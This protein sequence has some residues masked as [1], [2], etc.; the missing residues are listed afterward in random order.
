MITV[1]LSITLL[2]NRSVV[3]DNVFFCFIS[4]CLMVLC[5]FKLTYMKKRNELLLYFIFEIIV[6]EHI[7]LQ[8]KCHQNNIT[9]QSCDVIMILN[10]II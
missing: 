4:N 2:N 9:I 6:L 8:H 1:V 3:A 7:Q 10:I 5:Y